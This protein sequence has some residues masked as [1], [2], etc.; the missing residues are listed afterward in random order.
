M[1][2]PI[3]L[4]ITFLSAIV[5]ASLFWRKRKRKPTAAL[6]TPAP[7]VFLVP[8][9]EPVVAPSQVGDDFPPALLAAALEEQV[10][11]EEEHPVD[12]RN[13]QRELAIKQRLSRL[14][15][16]EAFSPKTADLIRQEI[17]VHPTLGPWHRS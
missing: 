9:L 4:T 16:K 17:D 1:T 5:L 2:T 3:I 8:D 12:Y 7:V 14:I 11:R 15:G 13:D 6:P 10:R